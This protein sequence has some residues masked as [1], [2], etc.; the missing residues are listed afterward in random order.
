M[1]GIELDEIAEI[2]NI[3]LNEMQVHIIYHIH[4]NSLRN[5]K[6]RENEDF[7]NKKLSKVIKLI[8]LHFKMFVTANNESNE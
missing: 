7:E 5:I 4:E 8:I 6:K 3:E 2:K 1:L